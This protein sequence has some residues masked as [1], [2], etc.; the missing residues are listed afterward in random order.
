MAREMIVDVRVGTDR[1]AFLSTGSSDPGR[2]GVMT[3]DDKAPGTLP[4]AVRIRRT[5]RW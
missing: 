5:T 4:Q 2:G 1:R 3:T